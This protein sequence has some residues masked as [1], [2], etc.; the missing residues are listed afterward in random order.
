M[1]VYQEGGKEWK[2]RRE[3]RKRGRQRK[4]R[5]EGTEEKK[6]GKGRKIGLKYLMIMKYS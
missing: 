3:G 1:P 5:R 6:G 2:E 4:E